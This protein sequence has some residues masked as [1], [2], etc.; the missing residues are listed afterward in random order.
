MDIEAWFEKRRDHRALKSID[1]AK[2]YLENAKIILDE[3]KT[4]S[5]KKAYHRVVRLS[6]ESFELAL[7]ACLRIIGIEYPKSHEVSDVMMENKDSFPS[8]FRDKTKYLC[9]ASVWLFEKRGLA[10]YGDEIKGEPASKLFDEEDAKKAL[11]FANEAVKLAFK[12]FKE[13][14]QT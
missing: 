9:E 12:L 7:K 5:F 11:S 2:D 8:W 3:A 10:M 14:Y 4:A 6:Q 13:F 1:I